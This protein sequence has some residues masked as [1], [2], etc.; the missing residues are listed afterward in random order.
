[1]GTGSFLGVKQLERGVDHPPQSSAE[2]KEGVELYLY[3][4]WD[5]VVCS[6]VTFTFTFL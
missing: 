1:M 5:F 2:V 4:L 3:P 6:R